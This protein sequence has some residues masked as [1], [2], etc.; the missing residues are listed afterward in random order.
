AWSTAATR[1]GLTASEGQPVT[2]SFSAMSVRYVEVRATRLARHSSGL[3]YAALGEAEILT[4]SQTPG[5]VV[6]SWTAPAD[7]GPSGRAARYD[8][9]VGACPYDAATAAAVT[10]P[11]P[12]AAGT[13][14]RARASGVAS[15]AACAV[16]TSFDDAGNQSAVSNTAMITVP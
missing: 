16:I 10:T 1:T 5:S 9:R 15:G 6:A 14:E 12:S 13:P 7:D 4:A 8:L 2:I 11:T 3:Y